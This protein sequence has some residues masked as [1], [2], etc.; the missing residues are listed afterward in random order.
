MRS[1]AACVL[2][3]CWWLPTVIPIR[4]E[5]PAAQRTE[6]SPAVPEFRTIFDGRSL[7]GWNG[8]AAVFRV[9]GEA[10]VGGQLQEDI[11]HNVFLEFDEEFSDF[12]LTLEFRLV[13]AQT[14]AGVQLRSRRIPDHHEMIGY[15]ADL[16]QTYWGCL[17]DESR[18]KRVLARPDPDALARV[19]RL[20]DWNSYRIQC[21]GRRIQLW[22]ND[23]Q[24]VDYHEEDSSI[25]QTGKIALQIHGGPPGEAWYRHIRIREL[26]R[27]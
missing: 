1:W 21:Q 18:R 8:D 19:L 20:T 6:P 15:Q 26:K 4:A 25:E 12:E 16:G 7:K 23:F 3:M 17:Y 24:T 10:I 11:P 2:V 22:I 14:N 27:H 9:D 13:G 5:G